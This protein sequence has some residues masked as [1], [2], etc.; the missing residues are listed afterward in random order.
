[1]TGFVG[2]LEKMGFFGE[3]LVAFEVFVKLASR[4][5]LTFRMLNVKKTCVLTSFVSSNGD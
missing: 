4:S 5:R 2:F 3:M 1:M